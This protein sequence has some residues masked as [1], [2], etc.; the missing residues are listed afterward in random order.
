MLVLFIGVFR[1]FNCV[2][3]YLFW[4]FIFETFIIASE[5]LMLD[6]FRS[7][8]ILFICITKLFFLSRHT[9]VNN[10]IFLGIF[11]VYILILPV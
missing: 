9:V 2:N 8:Q 6:M 7:Y 11:T 1:F 3:M 5:K 4:K 10:H